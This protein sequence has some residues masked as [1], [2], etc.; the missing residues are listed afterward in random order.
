M[1]MEVKNQIK[2]IMLSVKYN[3]MRQ[4]VNKVTFITNILF[5]II[6]RVLKIVRSFEYKRSVF[7]TLYRRRDASAA[8]D[9]LG[10]GQC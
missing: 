10:R 7:Q 4:M 6:R 8:V 2:V 9:H 3:V 5:M 1:L